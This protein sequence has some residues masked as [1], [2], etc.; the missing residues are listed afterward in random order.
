[1]CNY[2]PNTAI[3]KKTNKPKQ[4]PILTPAEA[5]K[6]ISSLRGKVT[7]LLNQTAD[8]TLRCDTAVNEFNRLLEENDRFRKEYIILEEK[9]VSKHESLSKCLN[10]N[11]A[12]A[13]RM[14]HLEKEKTILQTQAT[15]FEK[16]NTI[17][18]EMI[19]KK[20]KYSLLYWLKKNLGYE[21]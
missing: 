16:S 20:G 10:D 15:Q 7:K 5:K 3:M 11:L 14:I 4:Q 9:Y 1:M 8:L 6:K 2:Y 19:E 21:S 18:L 13:D 17:L 12:L